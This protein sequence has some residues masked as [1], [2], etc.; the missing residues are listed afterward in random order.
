M[1]RTRDT[2]LGLDTHDSPLHDSNIPSG[3]ISVRRPGI[4]DTVEHEAEV[5]APRDIVARVQRD[6][7]R[8][9]DHER[10]EVVEAEVRANDPGGVRA[11]EDGEDGAAGA[12]ALGD[13]V[14]LADGSPGHCLVDGAV[15]GLCRDQGVE[16]ALE[17]RPRI[18]F[19]V[20]R[21]GECVEVCETIGQDRIHQFAAVGEVVV[22][23][24]DAHARAFGDPFERHVDAVF[25]ERF[26][27]GVDQLLPVPYR[28]GSGRHDSQH[29]DLEDVLNF[30][31]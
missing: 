11:V 20:R 23:G 16:E 5:A 4:T 9:R 31:Y 6:H 30:W 18:G 2:E 21:G 13:D 3:V 15:A 24:S 25:G 10:R 19:R 7:V 28:I 17:R 26:A 14:D 29:T 12:P 1:E 22:Q 27:R 8:H